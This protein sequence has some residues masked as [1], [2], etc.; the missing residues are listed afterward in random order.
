M[1]DE[2]ERLAYEGET[3]FFVAGAILGVVAAFVGPTVFTEGGLWAQLGFGA[4]LA[5][6]GAFA[7]MAAGLVVGMIVT[8]LHD[9]WKQ[10][11]PRGFGRNRKATWPRALT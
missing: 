3:W 4:V 1:S 8:V 6:P 9:D 10:R 2:S 7:G 5:I 11:R